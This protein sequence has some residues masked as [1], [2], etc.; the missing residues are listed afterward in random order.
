M[1]TFAKQVGHAAGALVRAAQDLTNSDDSDAPNRNIATSARAE[2]PA[3]P[4]R[5]GSKKHSN[6]KGRRKSSARPSKSS[7][8]PTGNKVLAAKKKTERSN[9]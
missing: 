9:S 3:A 8:R 4:K 7:A 1:M 6:R 5:S 2:Q